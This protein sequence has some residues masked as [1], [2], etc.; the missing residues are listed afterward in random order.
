MAGS[1]AEVVGDVAHQWMAPMFT[2][3]D[4][5]FLIDTA[6]LHAEYW[7]GDLGVAGELRLRVAKFGATPEDR[8]RLRIA[9]SEHDGTPGR[10]ARL[11]SKSET[12][13]R[14]RILTAVEGQPSG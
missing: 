8:A 9:V 2:E 7:L 12:A 14:R 10:P 4:W 3:T 13:R 5:S 6:V 11:R 1:H